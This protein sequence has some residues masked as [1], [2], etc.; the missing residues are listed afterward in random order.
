[1]KGF[2][3][4]QSMSQTFQGG[5][6]AWDASLYLIYTQIWVRRNPTQNAVN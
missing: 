2:V 4:I 1:M 5:W 6:N 3:L